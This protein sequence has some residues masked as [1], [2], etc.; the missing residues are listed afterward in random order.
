MYL[1][2]DQGR[3]DGNRSALPEVSQAF[4]LPPVIPIPLTMLACSKTRACCLLAPYWAIDPSSLGNHG[5]RTERNGIIYTGGAGFIDTSHLRHCCDDTKRVYDQLVAQ[6]GLPGQVSTYQGVATIKKAVPSSMW[7]QVARA[8]GYSDSVGY[9]I[10]SYWVS[11]AGEHNSAFSPEDLCSNYLGTYVAERAITN[12]PAGSGTNFNTAVTAT[13]NNVLTQLKAQPLVETQKA[14]TP[15]MNCWMSPNTSYSA[16]SVDYWGFMTLKRRNFSTDPP[17]PWKVGHPSDFQTP[18]W[19][20]QSLRAASAYYDFTY[21]Y[22]IGGPPGTPGVKK[23]LKEADFSKEISS[24][25][26][27]AVK[28]YGAKYAQPTCP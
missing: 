14:F 20:T 17:A 4:G 21:N 26:A 8:I 13:L 1:Y 7:I 23:T 24:I 15:I 18:A 27:D 19:M 5:D 28:K 2:T 11:A 25:E 12:P 22:I 3:N 6:R 10:T 9:E 16:T